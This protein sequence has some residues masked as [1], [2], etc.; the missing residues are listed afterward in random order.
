[1]TGHLDRGLY[2]V[3]T[4]PL[5]VVQELVRQHHYAR[6][7]SNTATFRHALFE[8]GSDIALGAAWWIPPT[9]AAALSVDE[10]WQRVINL[11][12]FVIVPGMPTNAAS[13]LLGASIRM[14]QA[15]GRFRTLLTY[16]D[17][18]QGHTGAIYRATNWDYL[19]IRPGEPV[20]LDGEGRQVARKAGGKTRTNQQMLDLGYVNTGRTRKHKFVKRLKPRVAT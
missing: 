4:A 16:A 17:E 8:R 18:G 14:I 12:R 1:M 15:D 11:T 2:E 9:K 13:F 20:Y 19:G 5:S 10:E 7:G 3:R 6:G